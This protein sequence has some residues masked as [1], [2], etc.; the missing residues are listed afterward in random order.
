MELNDSECDCKQNLIYSKKMITENKNGGILFLLDQDGRSLGGIAKLIEKSMR[1]DKFMNN[2]IKIKKHVDLRD[3]SYLPKCLKL[4]GYSNNIRLI[5]RSPSK[6]NDLQ[7]IGINAVE[8]VAYPYTIT[9]DNN[10]YLQ[11]KK[12][13]RNFDFKEMKCDD[14]NK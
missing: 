4:M 9:S 8:K 1:M 13:E 6:V 2:G 7:K 12:C 3:Y 10:K 5:T 14:Y 11:M